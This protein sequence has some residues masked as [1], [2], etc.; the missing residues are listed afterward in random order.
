M[1]LQ[2]TIKW[3]TFQTE[4]CLAFPEDEEVVCGTLDL[5]LFE[6]FTF[7]FE[8]SSRV[9]DLDGNL[10][11]DLFDSITSGSFNVD[12]D[13]LNLVS[14]GAGTVTLLVSSDG[15]LIRILPRTICDSEQTLIKR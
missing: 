4:V 8:A 2:K 9:Y 7:V 1:M 11:E 3:V 15:S 12:G 6:D 13:S 5:I 10:V 14:S